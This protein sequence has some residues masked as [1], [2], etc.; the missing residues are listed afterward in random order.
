MEKTDGGG[1]GGTDGMRPW[2]TAPIESIPYAT[3]LHT[4]MRVAS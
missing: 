3:S 4:R 2:Y 1:Y